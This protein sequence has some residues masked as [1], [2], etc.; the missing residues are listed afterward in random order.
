MFL[1]SL[2]PR[3]IKSYNLSDYQYMLFDPTLFEGAHNLLDEL[4]VAYHLLAYN[5]FESKTTT[6]TLVDLSRLN[7]QQ[8]HALWQACITSTSSQAT[9]LFDQ[10]PIGQN[11]IQS[12]DSMD[13]MIDFLIQFMKINANHND[14]FFRYFDPRVGIHLNAI[15]GTLHPRKYNPYSGKITQWTNHIKTWVILIAGNAYQLHF[16]LAEDQALPH[17]LNFE[18]IG[19]INEFLR[20][21]LIPQYDDEWREIP[22]TEDAFSDAYTTAYIKINGEK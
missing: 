1:K 19:Q 11:L 4:G 20:E 22:L 18:E 15:L 10:M 16:P 6:P 3:T 8:S 5:L 9:S 2:Q 14:Y 21:A 7:K 17:L 12:D 13:T